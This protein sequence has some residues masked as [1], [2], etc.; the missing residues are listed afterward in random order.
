MARYRID[1]TNG[2]SLDEEAHRAGPARLGT[3]WAHGNPEVRAARCA[4]ARLR[5]AAGHEHLRPAYFPSIESFVHTEVNATPLRDRL[6]QAELDRIL[7]ESQQVLAPFHR[8]GRLV[9]PLA[10]YVLA[11]TP[12]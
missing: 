3:Y 11:A 8:D 1:L 7:A 2:Q 12:T 5:V 9:I 6:L 4:D 10:G